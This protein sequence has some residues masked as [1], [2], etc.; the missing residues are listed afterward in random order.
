MLVWAHLQDSFEQVVVL[1]PQA[2]QLLVE[3]VC[4]RDMAWTAAG[5][6]RT[7]AGHANTALWRTADYVMLCHSVTIA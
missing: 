3:H 1:T 2:L 4:R 7:S 6:E 5:R